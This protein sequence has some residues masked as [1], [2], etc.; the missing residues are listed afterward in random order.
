MGGTHRPSPVDLRRP[1]HRPRRSRDRL[2]RLS[3]HTGTDRVP[4][5]ELAGSVAGLTGVFEPGRRNWSS[6]LPAARSGNRPAPH[7]KCRLGSR[8][9]R[10]RI[11]RR[12]AAGRA[13]HQHHPRVLRRRLPDAARDPAPTRRPAP[14]GR[15]RQALIDEAAP[16]RNWTFCEFRT[17]SCHCEG[18]PPYSA[19]IV[20]A[21]YNMS[22]LSRYVTSGSAT[23][24]G[25]L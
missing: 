20:R 8:I 19:V 7:R 6:S 18:Q 21:N 10:L 12:P 22:R 16:R 1:V 15:R 9:T 13:Q 2:R 11:P 23:A 14:A 25:R 5:A 24:A 17:V 4:G 3:G